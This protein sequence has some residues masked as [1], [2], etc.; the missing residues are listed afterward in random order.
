[1]AAH[2]FVLFYYCYCL[3][4]FSFSAFD[5]IGLALVGASETLKQ[6]SVKGFLTKTVTTAAH[7]RRC[8]AVAAQLYK[9]D[10]L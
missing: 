7:G 3:C 9:P 5:T 4:G 8:L 6:R 1:M 10:D 2:R